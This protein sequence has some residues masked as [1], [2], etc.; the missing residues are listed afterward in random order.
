VAAT[1]AVAPEAGFA[2]DVTG[3]GNCEVPDAAGVTGAVVVAAPVD[4]AAEVA[5]GPG[6]GVVMAEAA[7]LSGGAV[8]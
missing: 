7:R 8:G 2:V 1:V 6:G 3:T 4:E 5:A